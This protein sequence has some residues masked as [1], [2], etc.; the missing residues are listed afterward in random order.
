MKKIFI[1]TEN[2]Q[3]TE[4]LVD[5]LNREPMGIDMASIVAPAGRGKTFIAKR[6]YSKNTD[7][8][9]CLYQ[10]KWS[11]IELMREITFKLS[12]D[13]PRMRQACFDVIQDEIRQKRR[14]IIIDDGDRMNSSCLNVL[15]NIH[16]ILSVPILIIG[17]PFL[18]QKIMREKRLRSR[19]RNMLFYR[20]VNSTDVHLYFKKAIDVILS[21][22]QGEIIARH[23]EGDFRPLLTAAIKAETIM[24]VSGINTVTN[25]IIDEICKNKK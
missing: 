11:H 6:I 19:T 23:C 13:R 14:V 8:V 12:G 9:Y 25:K 4:A 3:K 7:T 18:E 21:P 24:K 2:Y 22:E 17:E 1:P 20:P 16:D 10:E 15:R 5:D